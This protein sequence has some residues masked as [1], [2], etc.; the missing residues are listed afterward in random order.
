MLGLTANGISSIFGHAVLALQ[1]T[2][3]AV[4][5]TVA[6]QVVAILLFLVLVP[7]MDFAGLA[8]ASSLVP[9]SSALL[10]YLYLKKFIPS[11]YTIFFHEAY[12]KIIILSAISSCFIWGIMQ[13]QLPSFIQM[14]ASLTLGVLLYLGLAHVW[15]IEEMHQITDIFRKKLQSIVPL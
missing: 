12:I 2:K 15:R 7:F 9:L 10:Y 13:L 5:I 4:A 3:A 11:L 8:L 1:K 6:S 14:I